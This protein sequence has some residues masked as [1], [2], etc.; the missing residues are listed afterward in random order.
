LVI[1]KTRNE[2][3][4]GKPEKNPEAIICFIIFS[5]QFSDRSYGSYIKE[6]SDFDKIKF[7]IQNSFKNVISK[8][9][10]IYVKKPKIYIFK[11]FFSII[12]MGAIRY[13]CPIRLVPTYILPA[14]ERRLLG[15][16]QFQ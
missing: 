13:S 8:R 2:V 10:R 16:F 15:K 1:L 12:P 14:K 3:N 7:E 4:F 6:S 5:H 11:I 9:R